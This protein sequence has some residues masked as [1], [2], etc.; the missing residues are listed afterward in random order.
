[1]MG[2]QQWQWGDIVNGGGM[3]LLMAVRWGQWHG[4]SRGQS[5]GV[6]FS[7]YIDTQYHVIYNI[8]NNCSCYCLFL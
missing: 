4:V 1:M 7:F 5:V 6:D 3:A 2:F 8:Y